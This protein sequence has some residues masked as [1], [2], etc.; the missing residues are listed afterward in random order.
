MENKL[1]E[2]RNRKTKEGEERQ[3][4]MQEPSCTARGV[5][6]YEQGSQLTVDENCTGM[7]ENK[8]NANWFPP[9]GVE[10]VSHIKKLELPRIE[11]IFCIVV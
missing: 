1:L 10:Q 6:G 4:N 7:M 2:N 5:W 8:I 11:R 9:H 3:P